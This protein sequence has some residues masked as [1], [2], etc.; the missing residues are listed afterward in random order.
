[1]PTHFKVV[2]SLTYKALSAFFKGRTV[3]PEYALVGLDVGLMGTAKIGRE[4]GAIDA[5]ETIQQR[6]LDQGV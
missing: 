2:K 5:G 3:T 4:G 1:M 6:R